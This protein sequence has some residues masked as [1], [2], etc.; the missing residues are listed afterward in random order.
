[1]TYQLFKKKRTIYA[2]FCF[3]GL[4]LH[5]YVFP[6]YLAHYTA[7]SAFIL[8]TLVVIH[9]I[10]VFIHVRFYEAQDGH[11]DSTSISVDE[12]PTPLP[13]GAQDNPYRR[14]RSLQ[15]KRVKRMKTKDVE[16]KNGLLNSLIQG[17][18]FGVAF[19]FGLYQ[20]VVQTPNYLLRSSEKRCVSVT[21]TKHQSRGAYRTDIELSVDG[22]SYSLNGGFSQPQRGLI[23]MQLGETFDMVLQAGYVNHDF[24]IDYGPNLC[25]SR[26][27]PR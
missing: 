7:M 19:G 13:S 14:F 17:L 27:L 9:V 23:D 22:Q 15:F 4:G 12:A 21:V 10:L 11:E 26:S 24:I 20:W 6:D 2:I 1:M 25:A 5:Y 16:V 3:I 8:I 18:I